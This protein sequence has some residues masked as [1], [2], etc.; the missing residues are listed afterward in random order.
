MTAFSERERSEGSESA[1]SIQPLVVCAGA[2]FTGVFE[3]SLKGLN[4]EC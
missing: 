2:Y 4:P 3:P 1:I